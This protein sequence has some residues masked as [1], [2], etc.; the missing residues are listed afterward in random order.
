MVGPY[1]GKFIQDGGG[2]Y[3]DGPYIKFMQS[4]DVIK[5]VS[6]GLEVIGIQLSMS[7]D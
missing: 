2:P 5:K 1:S 7:W 6:M 3:S 4:A